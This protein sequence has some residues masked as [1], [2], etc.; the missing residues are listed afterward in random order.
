MPTIFD[1]D[2]ALRQRLEPKFGTLGLVARHKLVYALHRLS[3][4][5]TS[6]PF[7]L[8]SDKVRER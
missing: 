6:E 3:I 4:S 1:F 8:F 5:K 7:F 2:A